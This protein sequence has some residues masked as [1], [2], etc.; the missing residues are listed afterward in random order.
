MRQLKFGIELEV[1]TSKE[2]HE[3]IDALRDAGINVEGARYGSAVLEN[4]WK[5]QPDGSIN[6][7][8]IVSPPLTDVE[9]LKTVVHV[10]RKELKVRCNK[11]TGLHV[12]HD[13]NDFTLNQIKN[14]YRLYNKYESNAIKSIINPSRITS[15]YCNPIAPLMN[16]LENTYTAE[17]FRS[18]THSRYYN[19][20]HKAYIKYGTIEFR[21]HQG[22]TNINEILAWIEFTHKLVETAAAKTEIKNLK[23]GRTDEEALDIM[24]QEVGLKDNKSV[25]KQFNRA[26]KYIAKLA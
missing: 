8:E 10:L 19:L 9:D 18:L 2:R 12:H 4:T 11:K 1:A 6:G 13:I 14:L 22:T 21:H 23:P 20:N 16:K 24:L 26:Q 5:V 3:V 17:D 25:V 15:A 7:W